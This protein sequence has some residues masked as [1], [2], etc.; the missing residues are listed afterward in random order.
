MVDS[1]HALAAGFMRSLLPNAFRLMR[2]NP[3]SLSSIQRWSSYLK[4][5]AVACALVVALPGSA[6]DTATLIRSL[7]TARDFRVKVQVAFAMGN[8]GDR[9]LKPH[10]ERALRDSNP[11]VRAAA[12]TAL[13][14]LGDSSAVPALRRARRDSSASVRMQAERSI[15]RLASASPTAPSAAPRTRSGS[16]FYPSIT[17]VPDVT[18]RTPWPRVRYVIVLGDLANRSGF[19]GGS[20]L[21][22]T[23]RSE[24]KSALNLHSGVVVYD[25]PAMIDESDRRQI[26]R[27]RLPQLRV[28]GTLLKV[29]RQRAHSEYSVRAEVQLMILSH[30]GR[31]L[32]GMMS[33]AATGSEPPRQNRRDQTQRLAQR[34]ISAA[35][36]SALSDASSA[37]Q[38]AARR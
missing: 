1:L 21:L 31:D 29:D 10:L 38:R 36:R 25:S 22:P 33:G 34:A 14:R 37:L 19:R 8:T 20:E 9:R 17:T 13:G 27:R 24:V 7:R 26:D 6:Q 35:V 30:P 16:G 32:R 4:A 12:A 3:S 28:D 15:A 18:E 5:A 2:T 23:L 11:A